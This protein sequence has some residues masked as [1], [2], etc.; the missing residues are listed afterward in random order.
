MAGFFAQPFFNN[1]FFKAPFFHP[2]F[3]KF[4]GEPFFDDIATAFPTSAIGDADLDTVFVAFDK[5]ITGVFNIDDF[6]IKIN[7]HPKSVATVS[8]SGGTLLE[9]LCGVSF[10]A[11]DDVT[12]QI[13]PHLDNNLGE[14]PHSEVIFS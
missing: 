6:E 7:G 12:I 8:G 10:L 1:G 3:H 11:T 2:G 14:L 13:V 9:V 5:T 4:F